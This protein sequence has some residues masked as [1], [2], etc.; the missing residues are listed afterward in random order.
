MSVLIRGMRMP[1]NC[2]E[3]EIK[4]YDAN[5]NEEYCPFTDIECLNIG[6]QENCPLTEIPEKHGRLIDADEMNRL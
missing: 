1:E 3:C 4:A 5:A 6:R 2:I